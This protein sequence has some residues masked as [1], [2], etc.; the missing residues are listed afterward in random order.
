MWAR[1]LYLQGLDSHGRTFGEIL[2]QQGVL[3]LAST[4]PSSENK[5]A[6]TSVS[7]GFV[8]SKGQQRRGHSISNLYLVGKIIQSR[9][10]T[11][12]PK[13][14]L[15]ILWEGLQDLKLIRQSL[16]TLGLSSQG[17]EER[18]ECIVLLYSHGVCGIHFSSIFA[19]I[20]FP[21]CSS[22]LLQFPPSTNHLEEKQ[23]SF[24]EF[25]REFSVPSFWIATVFSKTPWTDDDA[26]CNAEGGGRH[27]EKWTPHAWRNKTV[28]N[29]NIHLGPGPHLPWHR[30]MGQSCLCLQRG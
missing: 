28:A 2:S 18:R 21:N 7:R 19:F 1:W 12:I 15:R 24:L 6:H 23:L 29:S 26:E 8:L 5:Y 20:W 27:W 11:Y 14:I 13:R 3:T 4:L 22:Q 9:N 25:L 17:K 10:T 30:E 16:Q